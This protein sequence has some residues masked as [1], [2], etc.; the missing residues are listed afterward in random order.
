MLKV[1]CIVGSTLYAIACLAAP[2]CDGIAERLESPDF[3]N[4]LA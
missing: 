2:A 1:D 3:D 4:S